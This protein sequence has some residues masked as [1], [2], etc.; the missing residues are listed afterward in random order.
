MFSP[1]LVPAVVLL[2]SGA[3][4]GSALL[5]QYVGG[6]VP[7]ELCLYE[8]WPYYAALVLAVIVLAIG[9]RTASMALLWLC[10]VLFLGGA[11]L[12]LY[13]VGIEQHLITGPTACSGEIPKGLSPADLA[14]RLMAREPVLCDDIQWSLFGISLA[15]FNFLAS[16]G[17]AIMSILALLYFSRRRSFA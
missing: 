3:V 7:C 15:G 10:V 5:F 14:A 12:G 16:L 9:R 11:V 6:L 1:R 13:H 2:A 17:I 8:R 4:V